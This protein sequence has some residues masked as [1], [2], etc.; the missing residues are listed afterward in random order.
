MKVVLDLTKLLQNGQISQAEY[1]KLSRFALQETS[2]LAF[3][4]LVGFGVIA[5]SGASIALFP[6]ALT[7]FIVG[8]LLCILGLGPLYILPK[9]KLLSHVC[10]LVGALLLSAG[11]LWSF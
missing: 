4:V 1:D 9:W 6:S 5:V 10:V 11:I 2:S 8:A 3:N 7:A